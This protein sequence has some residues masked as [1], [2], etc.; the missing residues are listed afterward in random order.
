MPPR[1][2]LH[3]GLLQQGG[4]RAHRLEHE[5]GPTS[6]QP[7][8]PLRVGLEVGLDRAQL[9]VGTEHQEA[10][11]A[12]GREPARAPHPALDVSERERDVARLAITGLANRDIGEQL[13][14]STR[15]VENH[16]NRLYRKLGIGS[17][18]EL[19]DVA[20][21]WDRDQVRAR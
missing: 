14:L 6:A 16:L 10:V 8:G 9:R 11:Q 17:R 18:A 1:P 15:T 7:P 2:W 12:R 5:R 3:G 21:L 13:Y 20:P 19:A 4:G